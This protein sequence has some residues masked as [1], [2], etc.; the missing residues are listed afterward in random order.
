MNI[1]NMHLKK[2][3]DNITHTF[4]TEF[5]FY[6]IPNEHFCMLIHIDP[7]NLFLMT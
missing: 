6:S 7:F 2:K 1:I 3:Y 5:I 4:T